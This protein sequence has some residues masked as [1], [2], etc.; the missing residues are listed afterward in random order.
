MK[1][2]KLTD[3]QAFII[4]CF[5]SIVALLRLSQCLIFKLIL[6]RKLPPFWNCPLSVNGL[7]NS[8]AIYLSLI[9]L[10]LLL[11]N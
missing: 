8:M 5:I 4:I 11:R 9:I 3:K 2:I 6:K 10:I 1:I 7:K